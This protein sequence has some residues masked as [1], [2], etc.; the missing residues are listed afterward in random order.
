M[1]P[2]RRWERVRKLKAPKTRRIVLVR[3]REVLALVG[4]REEHKMASVTD[5]AARLD[6]WGG[7]V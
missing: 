5:E 1:V 2:D 6:Y 3:Y 4:R 7:I